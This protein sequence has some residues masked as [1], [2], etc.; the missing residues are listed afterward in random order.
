[1]DGAPG[2]A[3]R[4]RRQAGLVAVPVVAVGE[5]PR[6]DEQQH[7]GEGHLTQTGVAVAERG[8]CRRSASPRG[9]TEA[10]RRIARPANRDRR[11]MTGGRTRHRQSFLLPRGAR[12]V[13]ATSGARPSTRSAEHAGAS[14]SLCRTYGHLT[15]AMPAAARAR[16]GRWLAL[17]RTGVRRPT[18]CP[19]QSP[20]C[21]AFVETRGSIRAMIGSQHGG[22]RRAAATTTATRRPALHRLDG[23]ATRSSVRSATG[24]WLDRSA[25]RDL[26]RR[27]TRRLVLPATDRTRRKSDA[28]RHASR[29]AC[30]G[31]ALWRRTSSP[32][33][34]ST[35][36]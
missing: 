3:G 30:H 31:R 6:A 22:R 26:R 9:D 18:A 32:L 1:M 24:E 21:A 34:R 28:Q 12:E 10:V 19:R 23:S 36:S 35:A 20:D 2:D 13:R 8:T 4:D 16:H 14:F 15:V 11:A 5:P 33:P 29:S 25:D 27:S 7:G 17:G